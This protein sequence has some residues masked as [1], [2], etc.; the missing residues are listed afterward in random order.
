MDESAEEVR[1]ALES[2]DRR[3]RALEVEIQELRISRR[4]FQ[5]MA[6]AMLLHGNHHK[7]A[8]MLEQGRYERAGGDVECKICRQPYFLHP[9]LPELPTFHL[10]CDGSIVKT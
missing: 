8:A 9:Q 4:G 6:R 5:I 7:W 3:I 1:K 10:L 2:K